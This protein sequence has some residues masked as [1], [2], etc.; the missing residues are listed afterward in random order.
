M[1][2][3][4]R[5]PKTEAIHLTNEQLHILSKALGYA[6][7]KEW[8]SF[9]TTSGDLARMREIHALLDRAE[10]VVVTRIREEDG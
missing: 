8:G 4:R 10:D 6:I 5:R 3:S 7:D 2:T 9:A 1:A